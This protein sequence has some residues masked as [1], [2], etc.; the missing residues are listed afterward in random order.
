MVVFAEA[1]AVDD[2]QVLKDEKYSAVRSKLC[3]FK[4]GN[5]DNIRE[6]K[7]KSSSFSCCDFFLSKGKTSAPG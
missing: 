4:E 5:F 7:S 1:T 6:S 3:I 2:P